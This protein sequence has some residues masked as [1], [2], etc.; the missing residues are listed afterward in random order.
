M[1]GSIIVAISAMLI[2]GLTSMLGY[3][4][5]SKKVESEEQI[6]RI[7][8]KAEKENIEREKRAKR[9]MEFY[10]QDKEAF[11]RIISIAGRIFHECSLLILYK[12]YCDLNE[13]EQK[14]VR[15]TTL[16]LFEYDKHDLWRVH[17]SVRKSVLRLYGLRTELYTTLF[18]EGY[19]K[20]ELIDERKI[21]NISEYLLTAQIIF[22]EGMEA[23]KEF[24]I[25]TER[26][27]LDEFED[28]WRLVGTTYQEM[29][30]LLS[31]NK[32]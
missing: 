14:V 9:E 21:D 18:D 24:L 32:K 4:Q 19:K 3:L 22:N 12:N 30:K 17:H 10:I 20:K 13:T 26:K 6:E 25:T 11:D 28:K 7:K 2:T 29:D 23:Q 5:Y 1:D 27:K 15:D 8:I 16:D 31:N